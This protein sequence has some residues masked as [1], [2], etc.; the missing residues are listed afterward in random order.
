MQNWAKY[1]I[2]LHMD[3]PVLRMVITIGDNM[4]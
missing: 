1:L 3:K 2:S 4:H